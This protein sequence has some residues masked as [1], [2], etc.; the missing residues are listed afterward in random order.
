MGV[1]RHLRATTPRAFAQGAC[2]RPPLEWGAVLAGSVT[3]VAALTLMAAVA[4]SLW[5]ALD[6]GP[7]AALPAVAG[8]V[9]AFALGGWVAAKA[10]NDRGRGAAYGVLA[11]AGALLLVL[12]LVGPSVA[13]MADVRSFGIALGWVDAPDVGTR[14]SAALDRLAR[15]GREGGDPPDGNYLATA[16]ARIAA[17][18]WWAAGLLAA[19]LGAA[20][21]AGAA[22]ASLH[23]RGRRGRHPAAPAAGVV[24]AI[25]LIAGLTAW[26]WPSIDATYDAV[27]DNDQS[28]GPELGVTLSEVA[29]HPEAMWDE[30]VTISGRVDRMLGP[31]AMLLGNDKPAVGD[32]V[33]VVGATPL[34]DLVLLAEAGDAL[35]EGKVAQVTGVVRPLDVAALASRLRVDLDAGALAAYHG[36]LVL[37]ARAIDLDVPVAAAA[38]DKEFTAGSAGYDRGITTDDVVHHPDRYLGLTVT[39]SDEVEEHLLTPHAFLLGDRALLAVSAQPRPELFVEA[40]AYVTGEVRRFDLGRIEAELGID[41]DDDLLRPHEGEPVIVVR[42]VVLVT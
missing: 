12:V 33:L 23:A 32:K 42:S 14:A 19:L 24:A 35:G 13:R 11:G 21:L 28:A 18:A 38:G 15:A 40:T 8:T 17:A 6:R 25:A 1:T 3:A 9:A 29:R 27:F 20:A 16:Y 31:H 39:V 30:T 22:G 34:A 37:V 10:A 5:S 41:L 7:A 2:R 36:R 26:L 4:L